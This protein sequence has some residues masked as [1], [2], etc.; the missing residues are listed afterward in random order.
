M[1]GK[2]QLAPNG[3]YTAPEISIANS[4]DWFIYFRFYHDGKEYLR[5][6]REGLN[7]Q[8]K[9][10]MCLKEAIVFALSKKNLAHKSKFSYSCMLNLIEKNSFKARV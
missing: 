4:K 10:D 6:K 8:A 7:L 9:Q 5:K 2:E 1:E 3:T